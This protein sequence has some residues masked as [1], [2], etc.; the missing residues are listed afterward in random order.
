VVEPPLERTLFWAR[1]GTRLSAANEVALAELLDSV[2]LRLFDLLG[3]LATPI[4]AQNYQVD[5]INTD[6]AGA[7]QP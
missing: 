3:P 1:T 6:R 4:D 2:R 5:P 7:G